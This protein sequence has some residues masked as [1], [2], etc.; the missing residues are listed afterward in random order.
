MT[1]SNAPRFVL[2]S[3]SPTRRAL[4]EAA[5]LTF[6]VV[7]AH[8]DETAIRD[9][10]LEQN[11]S[12]DR[13]KIAEALAI[14]KAEHVSQ[15]RPSQLTVG[16]DQILTLGDRIFEKPTSMEAARLQLMELRGRTH[17][18]HATTAIAVD[19]TSIWHHTSTAV[20]TMRNFSPS[21]LDAYLEAAGEVVMT[22]VGGYQ[23]EGPAIQLFEKITGD[24]TT[25]LGL[26][27]L[28]LLEQLRAKEL[29]AS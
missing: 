2:A 10:R 22:S 3:G 23:I 6:D 25:I 4:L 21:A 8:V 28:P 12:I 5:G 1:K 18:L 27:I 17:Q 7:P 14:A 20:L 29:I 15:S 24:Y 9:N 13:V 11:P 16:A 19:G 26:P